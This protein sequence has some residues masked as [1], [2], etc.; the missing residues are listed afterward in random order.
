[1]P[2]S[3]SFTSIAAIFAVV[4]FAVVPGIAAGS[5]VPS[6][7]LPKTLAPE[8]FSIEL[9]IDPRQDDFEGRSEIH[10]VV[11]EGTDTLW[12]HGRDQDIARA[13]L[14]PES[15]ETLPLKVESAHVSGVLRL[16]APVGIAP[17]PVTLSLVYSAPFNRQLEGAYKLVHAGESYVMTQM[18]PLGARLA[19]PGM[20]EPAFKRPWDITLVVPED[21]N[22]VANTSLV[23]E[24]VLGDGWKRLR[25]AR[26]ENLPSYLI[27]FAVG[28][29]DIV[30]WADIPANEVRP[31]PLK[32]RGIAAKGRGK[33]LSYALEHTGEIVAALERY[34]GS[35]YP[36]DKLDI[37]AAPDFSAGAMENAGLITYRDS[38]L[39]INENSPTSQRQAYWGVHAHELAHQWFGDLVT[40]PWWD[41]L[42]LNEAFATW[43]G[44]R[45]VDGLQPE[46]N[47]Q[48]SR[49]NAAVFAMDGD[50]LASTRRIREPIHDFTEIAAAF[51]GITYQ[52]GGA[53]LAMFE[54]YVGAEPFRDGIRRYLSA[55][56][57]G[58]ATSRDLISAVAAQ[59]DNPAAVFAAFES[60]I[61]QSGVPFLRV[62]LDCA[63][64]R[65]T[66]RIAQTRYLPVGSEASAAQDWGVPLCVRFGS[67]EESAS[68]CGLIQGADAE[69]ALDAPR[70]PD[71]V[72]PNAD[73]AGYYRYALGADDQARLDAAFDRLSEAEQRMVADSLNAA[74]RAGAIDTQAFMAALPRLAMAPARQTA[75]A[76][77]S[78]LRWLLEHQT[79]D[80]TER[81]ALR[82]RVAEVYRPRLDTLGLVARSGDSD[83]DRLLRAELIDLLADFARDP[84]L[85]AALAADGRRVL[86]L[87]GAGGVQPNAVPP[88][89]RAV[90]LRMAAVYGQDPVFEAMV[91]AFRASN[92]SL[93]RG[94][95]LF[96]LG[97]FA[98]PA[99]AQRARDLSLE[100]GTRSNEMASVLG[101]QLGEPE[102]R[103]A[104]RIWLREK[105][106][107]LM[108]KGPRGLG[109]GFVRFDAVARCSPSEA[110]EIEAWHGPRL[111]EVE[112]G[113]RRL[114]Q[115]VESIR[116]CAA[117][118]AAQSGTMAAV[119]AA[120]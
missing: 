71:W 85:G 117:L 86:G 61:D 66:L 108:A 94:Q 64:D 113:P 2:R 38:L 107:A 11:T 24:T 22:A 92:D 72:M 49:Q 39:F 27:A 118:K 116:L 74:F 96:A 48:R 45:I 57:G 101:A 97:R 82:A 106:D 14:I 77:V 55:H 43:M 98:Q 60:F 90:A 25:F 47:A 35:A 17:G 4:L 114:A 32:L 95:L 40:M 5:E 12:L 93:L 68:Q 89:R 30:E 84:D 81:A 119:V 15:G 6:G 29:W 79:R 120:D 62:S 36:F 19:F 104:A 53:V 34:F 78:I 54:H 70:C 58:N 67:G 13:V 16:T 76:P 33:D 18:E 26:T 63:A 21:H 102:L 3:L 52:K 83:D 73:G 59:S 42:W 7:R 88:D 111:R 100:D 103:D 109:G 46:F 69:F 28:P 112:G 20:D 8:S 31:A 1:M 80:Q 115:S 87:D 105:Y 51:D 44:N 75:L 23:E 41:D 10:A 50:S 110:A 37:L 65:P 91:D 99:L 56:A 9:K